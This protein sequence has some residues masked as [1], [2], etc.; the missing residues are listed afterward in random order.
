[1]KK[2]ISLILF[3]GL[4]F[5]SMTDVK[6]GNYYE[7]PAGK[8]Y[9]NVDDSGFDLYESGDGFYFESDIAVKP[10]TDY[11][12]TFPFN[13]INAFF[14]NAGTFNLWITGNEAEP[15]D[16]LGSS[17]GF[18]DSTTT[19]EQFDLSFNH[20]ITNST[21]SYTFNTGDNTVLY[22]IDFLVN[23]I[24]PDFDGAILNGAYFQLEEG[25]TSTDFEAF[26][27][28]PATNLLIPSVGTLTANGV[29]ITQVNN[30]EYIL[31]GTPT[32]DFYLSLY[33]GFEALILLPPT[34]T[35]N[36]ILGQY[37]VLTSLYVG[38]TISDNETSLNLG[39]NDTSYFGVSPGTDT[40]SNP[41]YIDDDTAN[42]SIYLELLTTTTFDNYQF[43][44][45]FEIG[46][47]FSEYQEYIEP[48]TTAPV[49][50]LNGSETIYVDLGDVY[51]ELG[52]ILTDNYDA[53][54][55]AT[56]LGTVDINTLGTY[57]IT[58]SG[59]DASGNV[60]TEIT[61]TVIVQNIGVVV[62]PNEPN[63][64]GMEWYFYSAIAIC[65]LLIF[66]TKRGR[67][68]VGLK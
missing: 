32:Q 1:M 58:Y 23:N 10:N 44:V 46:N 31:N 66:G 19:I 49:I 42:Y 59:S 18:L 43:K 53:D 57:T 48:D 36:L 56:V 39:Q 67:K 33:D 13:N 62:I 38:G 4:L 47:E 21:I 54:T 17:S 55:P 37:Y 63:T 6:A 22:E 11:T 61:R 50:T 29:T 51:T 3:I 12:F 35:F 2:I 34:K 16:A 40:Q 45:Q 30:N 28:T 9:F 7:Y 24:L 64:M 60:A 14:D 27:S 68:M 5:A 20:N 65:V 15:M 52:A 41:D 8:N 26:A 25:Q